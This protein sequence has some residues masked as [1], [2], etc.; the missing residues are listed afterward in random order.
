M[1]EKL[2]HLKLATRMPDVTIGK[3]IIPAVKIDRWT[4]TKEVMQI[5]NAL[6]HEDSESQRLRNQ[7]GF[8]LRNNTPNNHIIVGHERPVSAYYTYNPSEE[9]III[10]WGTIDPKNETAKLHNYLNNRIPKWERIEQGMMMMS[11]NFGKS[12]KGNYYLALLDGITFGK[13]EKES[14]K[15]NLINGLYENGFL[16][17]GNDGYLIYPAF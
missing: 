6:N 12:L 4:P 16:P 1:T 2:T 14:S 5:L 10:E 7:L 9:N 8:S 15:G 13:Y 3:E 11:G 17:I